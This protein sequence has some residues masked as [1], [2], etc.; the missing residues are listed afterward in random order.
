M[1]KK[2]MSDFSNKFSKDKDI[3]IESFI[4]YYGE[5]YRE[6]IASRINNLNIICYVPLMFHDSLMPKEL[7]KYLERVKELYDSN[8]DVRVLIENLVIDYNCEELLEFC[9]NNLGFNY[10]LH[11]C[12]LYELNLAILPIVYNFV[13]LFS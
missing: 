7:L 8:S 1:L 13:F 10:L 4:E 6:K 11:S 12:S 5:E 2:Y 9:K 3:I